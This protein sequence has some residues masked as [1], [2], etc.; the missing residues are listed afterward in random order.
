MLEVY[1]LNT[2]K[3]S[4]IKLLAFI[5]QSNYILWNY[6]TIF[7]TFLV[8][9]IPVFPRCLFLSLCP[10]RRRGRWVTQF[11]WYRNARIMDAVLT[12][13]VLASLLQPDLYKVQTV[14]LSTGLGFLLLALST[15]LTGTL[16]LKCILLSSS[17]AF[18]I[19]LSLL[20][21]FS[22]PR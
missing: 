11:I 22:L 6:F 8:T 10:L 18:Y 13:S 14:N 15:V 1:W 7:C 17:H 2:I 5:E 21:H 9:F 12:C 3:S 16:R 19:K 20:F 4:F